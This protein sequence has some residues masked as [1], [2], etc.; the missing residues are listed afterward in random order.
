MSYKTKDDAKTPLRDQI[1]FCA[2]WEK[3]VFAERQQ[4]DTLKSD[5]AKA[6]GLSQ[7]A[8][9]NKRQLKLEEKEQESSLNKETESVNLLRSLL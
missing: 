9:M 4:D 2:D 5:T 7:K 3:A 8:K 6:D 1:F